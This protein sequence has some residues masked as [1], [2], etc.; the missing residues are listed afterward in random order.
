MRR[1]DAHDMELAVADIGRENGLAVLKARRQ[2]APGDLVGGVSRCR[3]H[4][5]EHGA[6]GEQ[7]GHGHDV[8][9]KQTARVFLTAP[10][11]NIDWQERGGGYPWEFMRIFR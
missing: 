7:E 10:I 5:C 11:G 2:R 1:I 6:A 9:A 3:G 4:G 8:S